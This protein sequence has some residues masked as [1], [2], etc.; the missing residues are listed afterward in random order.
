MK[1][2]VTLVL[3]VCCLPTL[4]FAQQGAH[5]RGGPR[6]ARNAGGGMPAIG[7]VIG[8]VMESA[9]N[10]GIGYATVGV[11][12]AKDSSVVA[13]VLSGENGDFTIAQLPFGQFI[14]RVNYLGYNP[15]YHSF[16]IT[17][18]NAS[19]DLGNFKL[20]PSTSLLKT[21]NV[22]AN[23]PAYSMSIDKKVFDVSK[24]L[25]SVGGDA[26]DVLKEVPSVNVD[27]DGNVTLRNGSPTIFVDG[28]RTTLTLDQIP[29]ES[30]AKIEVIT[31]PSAKYDAEGMSGII[32]IVLKKNR[33]PGINGSLRAGGDTRGG[34][35][36]GGNL[37]IYQSPFNLTMS[38]FL[39]DRKGPSSGTTTRHNIFDDSWLDQHTTGKRDGLFQIGRIG[40]DYFLDNRNT[41]SVEGSLGGGNFNSSQVLNSNY[42][43]SGKTADSS[44][45]ANTNSKF[46]F[47][48]YSG[49]LG[50][51]HNFKKD[52]HTLTADLNLRKSTNP[53]NG[54]YQSQSYDN[55]GKPMAGAIRQKNNTNGSSTYF[56]GQLDYV[57]PLTENAKL[58]AGLKTSVRNSNSTYDVFDLKAGDYVPNDY[59]SSD[60]RFDEDIYAG[61]VQFSDQLNKFGYQL[62]LRAE[63]YSYSGAVPSQGLTFKPESDKLGLYPSVFLTYKFTDMDQVQVNYSRRVD[64]PNFWQRIPYTNFSDPLNLRRGNPDLKPEYTNSFELSYNKII[65]QSNFMTTLYF[66]NTDNNITTYTEPYNNSKDTL[67]SYAINA[68]T[69]NSYGAEF[70]LQTQLTNWWNITANLNLFQ[71]NISANVKSQDFSNSKFSGFAKLNSDMK[72]PADFSLQL[73][74]NYNAPVATP[75]GTMK[76]FGSI[77]VGVK[78]DLFKKKASL[79]LSLSD[80]LNTRERESDYTI[81]D[82]FTQHSVARRASRFLR[83][84]FTYNFGKQNFQLFRR[85]SNKSQQQTQQSGQDLAPEG[86]QF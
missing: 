10:K 41:L 4:V 27:I 61:Y 66:R 63:Q 44:S 55:T 17:P 23:K 54:S 58:E 39:N 43:N 16:S 14:L 20:S 7:Q 8:K 68:K 72:L 36:G 48:F 64:R 1:K 11:L 71:T 74:G 60:Y 40:L 69:N 75:Q 38:Y 42:L 52:G 49:D 2:F 35:N 67:I 78:K 22:T 3:M 56:V 77:D 59:L 57:N 37:N 28:K 70:T 6:G 31:N 33:K 32:N 86:Q 46:A 73:S 53:A 79:T 19:Q 81:P 82:V 30:I 29:A 34:F 45:I 9:T 21:V 18:K 15:V 47:N 50:Y 26:T 12:H 51:K 76:N 25:T 85:K 5:G 13:G 65:G 80:V 83:L 62:G 24:S 84:N